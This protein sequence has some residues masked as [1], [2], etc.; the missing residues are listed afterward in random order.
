MNERTARRLAR[1]SDALARGGSLRLQDAAAL[2]G[3]SEM[4]IRRD[5]VAGEGVL[6]LMGGHLVRSDDPRYA[7][8]YDLAA[9]QDRH[10]EAK[11]R[12]CERAAQ[13]IEPGDT[14][15][16][17]CG[18]TLVPLAAGLPTDQ[19][20]TVVTYA[21]NVADAVSALPGVRLILLG[22]VY[23]GSSRSFASEAMGDAIRRLGINK[24]FLS[25]AGV[26]RQ[27]GLSCFHFHE[28]APKQAAIA[29][30]AHR[31]LVVDESKLGVIRPARF[32]GLEEVDEVITDGTLTAE[33]EPA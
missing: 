14:L 30:A 13:R 2:C 5:L 6:R 29:T 22:G 18:T 3:V 4:T 20:L 7:P 19:S 27:K 11:R 24:A 9:Q 17:D 26:H 16:I 32:A 25:A 21:L 15:F 23:H 12:L 10:A 1:L 28:V 33:G 31:L 8:V